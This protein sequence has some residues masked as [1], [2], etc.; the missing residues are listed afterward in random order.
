M[1]RLKKKMAGLPFELISI[2]YAEEKD[3]IIDF[4]ENVH[5][6]FPVLLD[7]NGEF[8]QKW[9]VISYP[10]T[11]VIDTDGKIVFGVNSAIEWDDPEVVKK[12]KSLL[13]GTGI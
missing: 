13:Q 12:I 1:N 6:D 9:N 3:I 10:S 8:A 7:H 2:N 4:M 11:F 5:V